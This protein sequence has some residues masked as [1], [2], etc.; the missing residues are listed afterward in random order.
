MVPEESDI[1]G[2]TVKLTWFRTAF[3]TLDVDASEETIARHTY[4]FILWL[5]GGFF[6]PDKSASRV[7][8]KW[9]PLLRDFGEVGR[10]S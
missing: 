2:C 1:Q 6:M 4:S 8:L 9:F 5:L 3:P 10:L 7:S